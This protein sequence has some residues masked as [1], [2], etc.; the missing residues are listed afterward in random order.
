MLVDELKINE[1]YEGNEAFRSKMFKMF[2]DKAPE[3]IDNLMK[4]SKE[5]N[6][7]QIGA[8][9]HKFRSSLDFVC[10]P[11]LDDLA[12]ELEM[13]AKSD[14]PSISDLQIKIEEV[15]NKSKQLIEELKSYP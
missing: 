13:S 12:K 10:C 7:E 11:M 6:V 3:S 1:M 15:V 2:I 4:V 14:S 9:A 8:L 5:Q